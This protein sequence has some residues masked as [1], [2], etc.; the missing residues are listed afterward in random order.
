MSLTCLARRA[1]FQCMHRYAVAAWPEQKNQTTFGACFTPHGHG[2][3]YE[4][5]AYFSGP[6]DP[7]TGMIVNLADVD[8]WLKTTL[9]SVSGKHLNWEVAEFKDQVPTTEALAGYLLRT[10]QQITKPTGVSLR[11]IRLYESEDLWVDLWP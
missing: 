11:K 10:L 1:S 2:H 4:I 9:E 5:E 6:V 3:N 8:R 7:V